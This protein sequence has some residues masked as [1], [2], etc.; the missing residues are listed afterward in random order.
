MC[1]RV[2]GWTDGQT[3]ERRVRQADRHIGG[4]RHIQAVE[5]VSCQHMHNVSCHVDR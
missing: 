4:Q 2:F 1:G 3:D 5:S